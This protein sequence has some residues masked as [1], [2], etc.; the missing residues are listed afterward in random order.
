MVIDVVLS[1]RLIYKVLTFSVGS[2]DDEFKSALLKFNMNSGKGT[3]K[4]PILNTDSRHSWMP[5]M[6]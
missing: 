4:W 6:P 2:I 5:G 3:L 1:D